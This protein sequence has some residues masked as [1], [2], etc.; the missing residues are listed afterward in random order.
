MDASLIDLDGSF[1]YLVATPDALGF[2]KDRFA[3]KPLLLTE[4]DDFVAVATEEIAIRS[5]FK[6]T[7]EVREAQAKEVGIWQR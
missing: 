5:A 3:F 7:Y 2:A 6:G 1:S 4:T